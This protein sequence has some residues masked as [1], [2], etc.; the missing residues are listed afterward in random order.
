LADF[1]QEDAGMDA[2][3]PT[4]VDIPVYCAPKKAPCP[5]CGKKAKRRRTHERRV[6]TIAY[7]QIVFLKIT[8]GEYQTRCGCCATFRTSPEG[9]LPRH[10]YDNKVREAVLDRIL[11]DGMNVEATRHSLERDFFLNLSTGF[12]YDCLHAAAAELDMAAH[13]A[14]VLRCFSGTLCV[15]ELH[16][17]Q[18]T[19][20]LA[21]DPLSDIPVA[22][23]LVDKNDQDHMR[24]FLGNLQKHGL[25]PKVVITDG[26]TLYPTLLQTLWP[27][28]EHQL[29]VFHVL[30][31]V[32]QEILKAVLRLRRGLQRR[33][34]RGR[35]RRRGRP[36]KARAC[37][38]QQQRKQKEKAHFIFKRRYLIVK[39]RDGLTEQE[40]RDLATMLEYLPEL[41]T[42]RAFADAM[43]R[44][45]AAEQYEEQARERWRRLQS[46]A[47]YLA[48]PE[49]QKVIET[50]LSQAKFN[51]MIA[52]L[53]NPAAQQVRTNNHVERCNRKLRYWEKVR[54]KWRRRRTLVRFLVLALDAWWQRTLPKLEAA[55]AAAGPIMAKANGNPPQRRNVSNDSSSKLSDAPTPNTRR[56]AA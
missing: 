36:S 39:R 4:V 29:C 40:Q 35:K 19:L 47:T 6:R 5:H 23:A 22:F 16:L 44:L 45:F 7:R 2:D 38:R 55:H 20:L 28:A 21:T 32:N 26:S 13:R 56:K 46:N 24:R 52:F 42:L 50:I 51:K 49:L 15:D 30:Q 48:V 11:D 3:A 41:G 37:R 54:Y 1:F 17:G 25:E 33:G 8:V 14:Q 27:D 34:Q 18:Y 53:R 12:V 9:I 31:D 43:Q 10:K